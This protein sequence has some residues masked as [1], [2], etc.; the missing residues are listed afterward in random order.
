MKTIASNGQIINSGDKVLVRNRDDDWWIISIFSCKGNNDYICINYASFNQCIPFKGNEKLCGTCDKE[1]QIYNFGDKVRVL[2]NKDTYNESIVDG[3][4][5]EFYPEN[6]TAY[7][8]V[9]K[10]IHENMLGYS[11]DIADI[12]ESDILEKI[13]K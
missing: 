6:E 5:I 8:I 12:K 9:F 4:I 10:E 1:K 2:L 13:K 11:Y 3:Y 7:Q